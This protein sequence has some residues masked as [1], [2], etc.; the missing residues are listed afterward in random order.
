MRRDYFGASFSN[1]DGGSP[2]DQP[3]LSISFTGPREKFDDR[4]SGRD[5][6]PF[7]QDSIDVSFRLRNPLEADDTAGVLAVSNRTTGEFLLEVNV[8]TEGVLRFI[9]AARRYGNLSDGDSN[10]TLVVDV[11]DDRIEMDKST[12]LVYGHAGDLLHQHSL[13]PSGVE[14]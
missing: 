8:A 2:D 6:A 7:D 12:F 9:R 1:L 5:D 10:Y 11:G 14:L 4:L 3:T 13:I